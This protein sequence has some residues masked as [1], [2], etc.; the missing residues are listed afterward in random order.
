MEETEEQ[1]NEPEPNRDDGE[2]KDGEQNANSLKC[3]DCGKLLRDSAAA[4]MH[5]MKTEHQ[6][7]S[8]STEAIKP[9]TAEEKA[10]RLADLKQKLAEKRAVKAKEEEGAVPLRG[11][12]CLPINS[13]SASKRAN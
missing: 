10:A 11:E 2:I 6:S 4:E 12:A 1:S 3:D 5:A 9:L 8:E 13:C 7:F